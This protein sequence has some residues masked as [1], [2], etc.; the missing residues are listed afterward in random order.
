[1]LQSVSDEFSSDG[2]DEDTPGIDL[3]DDVPNQREMDHYAHAQVEY[4]S[5]TS[6]RLQNV[7]CRDSKFP[8]QIWII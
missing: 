2:W 3:V 4:T 5:I 6:F 8:A 1:M 7:I